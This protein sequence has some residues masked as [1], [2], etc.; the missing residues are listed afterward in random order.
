ML[1]GLSPLAREARTWPFEQARALLARL[2]RVR[3]ASDEE[4]DFAAAFIAEG[5]IGEALAALP[6]LAR[7]VIL[8]TGYGASGSASH[9]H[10]Q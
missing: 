10:V 8:E 4:R 3:L 1:K 6:A 7:P 2:V 9:R 5:R